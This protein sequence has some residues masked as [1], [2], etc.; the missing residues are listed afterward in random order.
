MQPGEAL[1][2]PHCPQLI[3]ASATCCDAP[4]L[5][6][7]SRTSGHRVDIGSAWPPPAAEVEVPEIH[8]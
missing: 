7:V 6:R 4:W 2:E 3:R 8:R 5:I 1:R